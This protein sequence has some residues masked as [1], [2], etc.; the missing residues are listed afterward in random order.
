MRISTGFRYKTLVLSLLKNKGNI[1]FGI[2]QISKI[3]ALGRA[4]CNTGRLQTILNPVN[5]EG[6][7][8]YMPVRM[9]I[10]CIIGA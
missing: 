3:H 4:G 8:V 6:T 1:T 2:I 9:G 7:L 10:P 5:T